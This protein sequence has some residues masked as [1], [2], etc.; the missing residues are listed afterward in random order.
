MKRALATSCAVAFS[1][2][3]NA[4]YVERLRAQPP[5]NFERLPAERSHD[6]IE[7]ADRKFRI[8]AGHFV[9]WDYVNTTVP[10]LRIRFKYP[11]GTTQEGYFLFSAVLP[12]LSP[13][14]ELKER[15]KI[16]DVDLDTFKRMG[17]TGVRPGTFAVV[18]RRENSRFGARIEQQ[19]G[20][21]VFSASLAANLRA[22]GCR[23]IETASASPIVIRCPQGDTYHL[24]D[25]GVGVSHFLINAPGLEGYVCQ[26][27][28]SQGI[29]LSVDVTDGH[30]GEICA[31]AYRMRDKLRSFEY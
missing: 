12:D 11:S 10:S 8:P 4:A 20:Q 1:L 5:C 6:C 28:Y 22:K 23:Q 26:V 18:Q 27:P 29:Y 13:V 3:G 30:R 25:N 15:R 19:A 17:R 9:P 14:R 21:W 24:Y 2:L 31:I 7:F 16:A